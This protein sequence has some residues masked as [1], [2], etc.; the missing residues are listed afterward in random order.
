MV[1]RK[2]RLLTAA[3]E[4][5]ASAVAA[6]ERARLREASDGSLWA[7]DTVAATDRRRK[8]VIPKAKEPAPE[9]SKS[10]QVHASAQRKCSVAKKK[11]EVWEK[12][13]CRRQNTSQ[14]RLLAASVSAQAHTCIPANPLTKPAVKSWVCSCTV[15]SSLARLIAGGAKG[16]KVRRD[17]GLRCQAQRCP[18]KRAAHRWRRRRGPRK[19]VGRAQ[20]W[21]RRRRQRLR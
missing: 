20:R 4:Y 6:S 8:R 17:R 7:I 21:R 13:C 12:I 16:R 11:K 2:A 10:F 1:K 18:R 15:C 3:A 14:T 9:A 19:H 5:D